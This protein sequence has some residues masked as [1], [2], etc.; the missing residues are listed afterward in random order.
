MARGSRPVYWCTARYSNETP[1][2]PGGIEG[3]LGVVETVAE[4]VSADAA[5]SHHSGHGT[6][7]HDGQTGA[8]AK[9]AGHGGTW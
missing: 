7:R 6:G 4:S 9:H 8:A 1:T 2:N 3:P 5:A